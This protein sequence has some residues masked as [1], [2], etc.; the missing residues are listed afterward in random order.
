MNNHSPF[1]TL[2]LALIALAFLSK[3]QAAHPESK[4]PFI[5]YCK[6][7]KYP[8][9]EHF[10]KTED[11]YILRMFRIQKKNSVITSGLQ[12]IILQHGLLDSSDTFLIND[13]DKAPGF[14]LAN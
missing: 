6:Y 14:M 8:V 5:D 12:P 9:E 13:E 1:I 11:G 2:L 4:Y 10:V 7:Y 3:V